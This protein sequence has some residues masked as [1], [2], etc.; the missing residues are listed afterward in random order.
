[1]ARGRGVPAPAPR[2][3]GERARGRPAPGRRPGAAG[4]TER[5]DTV[6][7][8]R[9]LGGEQ[10]EGRRAVRELLAANRRRVNAL[11][12]GEDQDPSALLA[13]ITDLANARR[14]PVRLVG[15]GRVAAMARTDA[16]QGVIAE[17]EALN[18]VPLDEL[19]QGPADRA[20]F[21]LVLEGVTDPH[22]LGAL[23]RSGDGAGVTG[24]VLPRHRS[25]HITPTVAKAAA[26]AIEH[27]PMA[28]VAGVPAALAELAKAG[29][30][31]VGLD[32]HGD[33]SLFDLTLATEP[34]A[35][36]LGAEGSGLS[37]L[38]RARCDV[39][40]RIP[41]AGALTSLNVAVAGALA[42]YEV[43]RRRTPPAT[44]AR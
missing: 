13:E 36:V 2:S 19:I 18:D 10:I 26:G 28:L 22:N 23:L 11:W 12:V 37:R 43:A 27:V 42:C 14:V 6:D 24:A 30:W 38:A 9:S 41:Q 35:L 8:F 15:R 21:L 39:V 17:A 44:A 4:G 7:S 31:S 29:V 40:V 34:V 1:V 32:E 5:R 25:V 20:T 3:S 16:P 33:Q